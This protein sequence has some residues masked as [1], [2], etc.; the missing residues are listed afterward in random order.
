MKA[1]VFYGPEEGLKLED[2][3]IPEITPHQ[4]LIKVKS[5]GICSGDV[6]RLAGQIKVEKVPLV[7]GHE[8]SGV[9]AQ[10]GSE[11]QAFKEG[12]NVVMFATGCGQC[13]Y[14][15][16]GK[17]N[18]C[19]FIAQN[20]GLGYDGAYAEYTVAHPKDLFKLPE[21]LP[22]EAGSVLSAP[23]ATAYHASKLGQVIAG[24]TTVIYGS[25][26]L[27]TQAIQLHKI[28]GA[29]VIAVD[30]VGEKLELAKSLGADE[31]INA[32]EKDPVKEVKRLTGGRGADVTFEFAGLPQ[33][34]LQAID[35]VRRGGR[36]INVGS[37][38]E[39]IPLKMMPFVD[40]GLALTKELTLQTVSHCSRADMVKLLELVATNT[41][42]FET[43]TARVPLEE[44]HRGF[45][46]KKS[47]NYFRVAVM[48]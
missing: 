5:C 44:I 37:I 46:V 1:A 25:G 14:C 11:V 31:V 15:R 30:V 17:D 47:G 26:C 22:F 18:V 7:L 13:Y 45:E 21:G 41:I 16:I 33:T 9:I 8:P 48:P 39:L 12:D 2:I 23:T 4:V 19:D 32:K 42:D 28:M 20:F 24:D 34:M 35:S 36:I 38:P 29:R 27:G 43:G 40:E 6:Q 3:K 10:V